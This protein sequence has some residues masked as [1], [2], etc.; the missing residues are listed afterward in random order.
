MKNVG[1]HFENTNVRSKDTLSNRVIDTQLE[2]IILIASCGIA[3]VS[4]FFLV[5]KDKIKD[6]WLIF[7]IKQSITWISGLYVVQKGWIEYPVR[8]FFDKAS[9]T[10]FEFE[11]IVYPVLCVF[12]NLYYPQRGSSLVKLRHYVVYC[13]AITLFEIILENHTMLIKYTGWT[14]YWTWLTLFITFYISRKSYL[15]FIKKHNK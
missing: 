5:P 7:L 11:F 15:W 10:S 4:V 6:A 1:Q 9:N 3:I 2:Y 8:E 14:W 12:F 13:S